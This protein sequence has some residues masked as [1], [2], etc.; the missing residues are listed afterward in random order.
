MQGRHA[1]LLLVGYALAVR[2]SVDL[3][4]PAL[5]IAG[6]FVANGI[7]LG[8]LARRPIRV[9]LLWAPI[10]LA[11]DIGVRLASHQDLSHVGIFVLADGIDVVV[12]AIVLRRLLG[13]GS[14]F[15]R[16][17]GIL[18]LT[19]AA[20]AGGAASSLVGA[21]GASP[22]ELIAPLGDGTTHA[23]L[24][25]FAGRVLGCVTIVALLDAWRL[26]GPEWHD[27][28]K[29]PSRIEAVGV[30]ALVI[31]S[32]GVGSAVPKVGTL[33]SIA[34]GAVRLVGLFWVP[35]RV[36]RR[37]TATMLAVLIYEYVSLAVTGQFAP[38]GIRL[39]WV[40]NIENLTLGLGTTEI[41]LSLITT[42]VGM[43]VLA[44]LFSDR[45]RSERE[46]RTAELR[47]RAIAE[48]T[49]DALVVTD[50]SGA[51]T[52][53]NNAAASMVLREDLVG[54]SFDSILLASEIE[55][56]RAF[57]TLVASSSPQPL[58]VRLDMRVL[59]ADG[60]ELP[61]EAALSSYELPD[62][63]TAYTAVLRD[64]SGRLQTEM[65]MR[66]FADDLE[67]S[68]Q[69]LAEFA[70]IASHDLQEPLRMVASFL[71]LLEDRYKGRLDDTADQFIGYAVDGAE[72]LNT[73]V[74]DLLRYSRAGSTTLDR[75]AV[76]LG[77][78]AHDTLDMLRI[79]I[80]ETGA[81]VEVDPLPTVSANPTLV[82]QVLQNLVSNAMKFHE[83]GQ[84]P[85]VEITTRV[86][87][88]TTVI[89]VVDHGIGIPED[90]RD[91]I[92]QPFR[93]LH[94]RE[95]YAGN[96]IGLA[97]CRK[98]IERHGGSIWVEETPGGGTTVCFHLQPALRRI[99]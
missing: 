61:V 32:A 12:A 41:L 62:G 76:D 79:Q 54:S 6:F 44:A 18:Y 26:P 30:V 59:C 27:V 68:N 65:D 28:G 58:D 93:R 14:S 99:A 78:T 91:I 7:I 57:A 71:K 1:A 10:L 9:W 56:G 89:A 40:P 83:P 49:N 16:P 84:P 97:V 66:R 23:A 80:Q 92:F 19:M 3:T 42:T 45:R 95:R 77:A 39:V 29:A 64:A 15:E 25:W 53:A 85:R 31:A 63:A 72:R 60:H 46:S 34:L 33:L 13:T 51:I 86:G 98:I 90:Q 73:L 22:T 8:M 55:Q 94:A 38:F 69:D 87:G 5:G 75:S 70:Y 47:F 36:G 52:F 24:L 48:S 37:A 82:N 17:S 81:Q 74:V 4:V 20:A 67:R 35:A 50:A 43:L 96:G 88:G 21:L 2:S 11:T